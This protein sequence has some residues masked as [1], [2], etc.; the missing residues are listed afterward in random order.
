MTIVNDR[1]ESDADRGLLEW[2]VPTL[3]RLTAGSAETFARTQSD[4]EFTAS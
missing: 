4:G 2:Q 3:R 1:D